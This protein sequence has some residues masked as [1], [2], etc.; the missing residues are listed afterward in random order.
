MTPNFEQRRKGLRTMLAVDFRR[1]WSMPLYYI[2]VGASFVMPILILVMT[3][4]MDGSVTV[5]PQTGAETVIEGFDNVWQII[6]S[7]RSAGMDMSMGMTAMCNLNLLY[8]L[9]A[10]PL[11]MFVAEDFRSGY[12]KNLFT[13]R[14]R[15][16]SYVLSKTLVG[17]VLGASMVIAFFA[18]SLAGGAV[19]GLP[20]DMEGF[21]GANLGWC[22]L[23]KVLL[24]GMFAALDLLWAAV[25]RQRL[26][27]SLVGAL[28]SGMF[29]FMMI[30]LLTP[31]DAAAGDALICLLGSAGLG[32]VLGVVSRTIL[33]RAD[34]V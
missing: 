3:T 28:G 5:D 25:A 6:G 27:L 24:M 16:G 2:T 23:C 34:L 11:C 22:L 8:F 1:L 10:V 17:F 18:G 13:L 12:A 32:L 31:L 4:M 15:K 19:A 7:V 20:F 26:W 30:P 9:V 33:A 29:L 14:P 21:T